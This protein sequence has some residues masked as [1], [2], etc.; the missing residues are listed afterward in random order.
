[1]TDSRPHHK[2]Q[3]KLL[4]LTAVGTQ[5]GYHLPLL[6]TVATSKEPVAIGHCRV[7]L[8]AKTFL[9]NG[10]GLHFASDE[11]LVSRRANQNDQKPDSIPPK[12]YSRQSILKGNLFPK[13]N[14][15]FTD[16]SWQTGI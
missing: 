3:K 12:A 15:P 13:M 1:M 10:V 2:L 16:R 7:S 5:R 8:L 11:V 14:T 9:L 4:R 6:K